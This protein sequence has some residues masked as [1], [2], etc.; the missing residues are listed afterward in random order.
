MYPLH[1]TVKVDT[2]L[3]SERQAFK[4]GIHQVGFA[5]ADTAPEIQTLTGN[6][7]P[8]GLTGKARQKRTGPVF[9]A[10]HQIVIEA[11][12]VH[13]GLLLGGIVAEVRTFE[14]LLVLF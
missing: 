3:A 10:I 6:F 5:T 8:L 14:I 9:I 4:E 12:Q 2:H 13:H 7:L 1:E 11:L